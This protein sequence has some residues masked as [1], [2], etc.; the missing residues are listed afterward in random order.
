MKRNPP[1][2]ELLTVAVEISALGLGAWI[3][4]W[5]AAPAQASEPIPAA[6]PEPPADDVRPSAGPLLVA[7]PPSGQPPAFL[8][9][10]ADHTTRFL[11]GFLRGNWVTFGF[12]A[13]DAVRFVDADGTCYE[14]LTVNAVAV[15]REHG[16]G[17]DDAFALQISISPEAKL[18]ATFLG[19]PNDTETLGLEPLVER[20]VA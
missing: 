19:G 9:E 12:Y 18:Q 7:P 16:G 5:H 20:P 3:T 14:G 11:R 1:L 4:S 17:P 2:L 10:G 13:G 8:A 6:D 15:M